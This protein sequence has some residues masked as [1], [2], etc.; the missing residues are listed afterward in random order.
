MFENRIDI[1]SMVGPGARASPWDLPSTWF[2]GFLS[3]NHVICFA[4]LQHVFA[5]CTM[6]RSHERSR[7][8][9]RGQ[10]Q[11]RSRRGGGQE[12]GQEPVLRTLGQETAPSRNRRRGW[13]R[14]RS[15]VRSWDRNR[16]RS[17][18][19]NGDRSWGRSRGRGMGTQG[20][21]SGRAGAIEGVGVRARAGARTCTAGNGQE[22]VPVQELGPW[23]ELEHKLGAG[24]GAGQDL[25][26][27]LET[28]Q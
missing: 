25:G 2:S 15:R 11:G 4:S 1:S 6:E 17:R 8:K 7:G 26:L 20:R 9:S 27:G 19:R 22:P 23:Q 18:G 24:A 13:D 16:D 14:S 21:S 12:P 5:K 3:L 28:G 10:S